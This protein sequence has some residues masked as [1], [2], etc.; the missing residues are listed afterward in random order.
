M[1]ASSFKRFVE[2]EF[3][4]DAGEGAS[5]HRLASA[6]WAVHRHIVATSR[7]DEETSLRLLLTSHIFEVGWNIED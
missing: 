6:R 1:D 7:C 5:E 3:G 4:Q 2:G